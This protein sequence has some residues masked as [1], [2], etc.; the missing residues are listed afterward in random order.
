MNFVVIVPVTWI[1]DACTVTLD[2]LSDSVM[3]C[4]G[5]YSGGRMEELVLFDKDTMSAVLTGDA[6]K[7]FYVTEGFVPVHKCT[8]SAKP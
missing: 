5:S 3:I 7:V 4:A 8:R 2:A 1:S 6:V